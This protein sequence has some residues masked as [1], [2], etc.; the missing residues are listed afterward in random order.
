M[1]NAFTWVLALWSL[2]VQG[3]PF[4]IRWIFFLLG[5]V[6][7]LLFLRVLSPIIFI[8]G[9]LYDVMASNTCAQVLLTK[10]QF[11]GGDLSHYLSNLW[12]CV[13]WPPLSWV[14]LRVPD[15]S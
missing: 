6:L 14:G 9:S 13:W 2:L 5:Y 8:A 10:D 12:C 15:Q 7:I 11:R 3:E 1:W 4:F